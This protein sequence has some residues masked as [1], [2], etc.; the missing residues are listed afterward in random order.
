MGS[1]KRVATE[2][3]VRRPRAKRKPRAADEGSPATNDFF[4]PNPGQLLPVGVTKPEH[5]AQ[6]MRLAEL[7]A[8]PGNVQRDAMTAAER[9]IGA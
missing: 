8:D 3:P 2:A 7:G 4:V 6:A 9:A 5:A 1:R